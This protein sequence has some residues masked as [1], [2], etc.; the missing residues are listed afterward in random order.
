MNQQADLASRIRGLVGLDP[1][2][3]E[4][5][6]F[7]GV[8]FLLNGRILVSARRTGTLLVQTSV[9]AANAALKRPGVTM[10]VMGGRQARNFIDVDY[11]SLETDEELQGWLSLAEQYLSTLPPK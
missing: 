4:K 10:M 11:D 8:A 2:V 5:R 7:G 1:R 3:T 9:E 6:M